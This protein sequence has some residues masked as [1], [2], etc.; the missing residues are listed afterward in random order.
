MAGPTQTSYVLAFLIKTSDYDFKHPPVAGGMIPA[1][2]LA[3]D[4]K[5]WVINWQ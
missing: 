4:V 1:F 3:Q 2:A 5:P